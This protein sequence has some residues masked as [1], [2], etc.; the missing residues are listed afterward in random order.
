MNIKLKRLQ[1]QVIVITGASSGIGLATAR[2][3]A[4]R[5][6][7]LV[8]AARSEGALNELKDELVSKGRDAM[9]VTADVSKRDDVREIARAAV[10]RYGRIDTWVNDAA[11]GAYGKMEDTDL[12]EMHR[13]FETNFWGVVY[14]SLEAVWLFKQNRN[15]YGAALINI[16]STESDRTA[17]LQGFY[18][19]TKHAVKAFTDALRMDL[20]AEAA[21]I[22]VTLIKPGAIDTP[23]TQN[24]KNYLDSEPKHVPPVYAPETVARAI[25]HCAETAVRDL[26]VGAGGKAN[27]ALGHYAPRLADKFGEKVFM[28][29][30]ESGKP[31]SHRDAL[32]APSE[33]LQE[34]GEYSGHVAKSS[35]YTQASLHPLLTGAAVLGTAWALMTL[36]SGRRGS[37]T[38]YDGDHFTVAGRDRPARS[39]FNIQGS[40]LESGS[41]FEPSSKP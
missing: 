10:E 23:F 30:T 38:H 14:G 8:L 15:A 18:A 21:P 40:T 24:A 2:M 20:E 36:W 41:T 29:G 32:D 13:L 3:A 27:A 22:S 17:P 5:G 39:R 16:G 35:L 11:I 31:P 7:R 25:L 4:E 26:F 9:T 37:I 28:P 1:E 34:R 12:D 19:A 6:A 33:N